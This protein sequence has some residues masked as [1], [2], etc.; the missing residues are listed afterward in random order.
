MGIVVRKLQ[1]KPLWAI[2]SSY[3]SR[4]LVDAAKAV[5]GMSWDASQRSWIG[6]I[7]AVE[8]TCD[9]LTKNKIRSDYSAITAE[10][11]I[12]HKHNLLYTVTG[13]DGRTLREYQ[14]QGVDFLICS[15]RSGAIEASAMGLGKSAMAIVA[16]RALGGRSLVVVPSSARSV[17]A[18]PIRGEISKWW[19]KALSN[20]LVLEGT[21]PGQ[22]ELRFLKKQGAWCCK[23]CTERI[24]ANNPNFDP[25]KKP[26]LADNCVGAL[27]PVA[28]T[29]LVICHYDI[30]H[31]WVDVLRAWGPSNI[32]WDEAHMLQTEKSRRSQASREIAES[33]T[34]TGRIALTGTPLMNRIRD[35]YNLIDTISPGRMGKNFFPF[36]K[37]FC[38]GHQEEISRDIGSVWKFDGKSNIDQLEK[39]LKHFVLRRTTEEVKLELPEKTR[40]VIRLEVPVSFRQSN[41]Q[42]IDKRLIHQV[43]ARAVDGKMPQVVS[44]LRDHLESGHSCIGFTFRQAVAEH[45][46]TEL[47]ATG[48]PCRFI[49]GGISPEKRPR[50]LDELRDASLTGPVFLA[51]TI[52]TCATAIDLTFATVAVFAELTYE[53]HELLQAEAR[54]YRYPQKSTVL[55]QYPIAMGTIE[56][57]IS[58]VV[59][60]RLD[61]F[62][63]LI[64]K[65][66]GLARALAG[67]ED[68][69]LIQQLG[70]RLF[71]MTAE[72]ETSKPKK[73]VKA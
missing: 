65:T 55:I 19:T 27:F 20:T 56:E 34:I 49:H 59:I 15:A 29:Q 70:A 28:A 58:E 64:G 33:S 61:T 7:D 26:V 72:A 21:R 30:L 42:A 69:D 54:P 16:L 32:V 66:D 50:I 35:L 73:K 31:A 11:A 53:P 13:A 18:D 37:V 67:D 44:L 62:E 14:K 9:I 1:K 3:F 63:K 40:Q 41:I 6:Y 17:W 45:L 60:D 36:G 24:S 23:H 71:A 48:F 22:H 8:A 2:Q 4:A 39:R 12:G 46:V 51:A 52:D 47:S 68:V 10:R 38:D 43:L 25:K 5:P 57:A